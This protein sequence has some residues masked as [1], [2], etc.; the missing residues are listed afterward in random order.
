MMNVYKI[1]E[2]GYI[3]IAIFFIIQAILKF[4]TDPKKASLFL[5]F[6]IIAIFMYFFKRW[7]RKK[8]FEKKD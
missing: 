2:I 4:S 5:L 6:A 7:F 3:A 1:F 8:R